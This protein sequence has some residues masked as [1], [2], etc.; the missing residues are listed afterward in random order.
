MLKHYLETAED[1]LRE[2]Q[3]SEQGLSAQ[4]A[5]DRLRKNG[6]NKL[7]EP[8]KTPLI[9]RFF[10]QMKDPMIH[11]LLVAAAVSGVL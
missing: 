10:Q 7:A 9:I 3:S 4:E 5:A 11:I 2:A 6:P 1:V 8:E